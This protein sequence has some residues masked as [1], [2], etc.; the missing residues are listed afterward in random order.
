MLGNA[1]AASFEPNNRLQQRKNKPH[2]EDLQAPSIKISITDRN[3][4]QA[5]QSRPERGGS[6]ARKHRAE[7]LASAMT[8]AQ[9]DDHAPRPNA[10]RSPGERLAGAASCDTRSHYHRD[11][12][13]KNGARAVGRSRRGPPAKFHAL[14]L[15]LGN[16]VLAISSWARG[17]HGDETFV[18]L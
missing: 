5:L 8:S 9:R 6:T 1:H 14:A 12:A 4:N 11:G 17:A 15:V 13:R 10:H 18:R 16:F 2:C 3:L 7:F